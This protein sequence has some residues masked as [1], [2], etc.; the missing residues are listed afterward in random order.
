MKYI[1]RSY[2]ERDTH[3]PHMHLRQLHCVLGFLLR[4][5]LVFSSRMLCVFGFRLPNLVSERVMNHVL[6]AN[7][8][9]SAR[10]QTARASLSRACSSL[11]SASV[12]V[13]CSPSH[14]LLSLPPAPSLPPSPSLPRSSSPPSPQPPHSLPTPCRLVTRA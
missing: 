1:Y 6:P 10:Q 14:S 7:T 3:T 5:C 2:R 13:L 9:V 8:Q 12:S 4:L 11:S